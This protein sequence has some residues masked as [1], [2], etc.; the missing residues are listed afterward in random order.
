MRIRIWVPRSPPEGPLARDE[1]TLPFPCDRRP[2]LVHVAPA[3][4]VA[5]PLGK[6]E[7]EVEAGHRIGLTLSHVVGRAVPG[8]AWGV[9]TRC[10]GAFSCPTASAGN[11]HNR[12]KV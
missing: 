8:G 6:R 1:E 10:C 3:S 4:L 2:H 12:L 7:R 5:P 9:L 11:P